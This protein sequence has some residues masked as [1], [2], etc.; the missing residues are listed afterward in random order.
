MRQKRR[1]RSSQK[2]VDRDSIAR[3]D[4]HFV[5]TNN[6]E[7]E[8]QTELR[9]DFYDLTADQV[10]AAAEC[11]SDE[12]SIKLLFRIYNDAPMST[13]T[14]ASLEEIPLCV[15]SKKLKLLKTAHLITR[16]ENSREKPYFPCLSPSRLRRV[17]TP[18]VSLC[19]NA[20]GDG[21]GKD[22]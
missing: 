11:F 1:N 6:I 17:L 10:V 13:T 20:T 4:P 7:E 19:H 14:L 16:K 15:A 9:N 12:T 8:P 3:T 21:K 22:D 2:V 5:D 18:F